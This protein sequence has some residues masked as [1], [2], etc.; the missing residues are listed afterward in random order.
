MP[1]GRGSA[2]DG[3][4][5][6]RWLVIAAAGAIAVLGGLVLA[7]G[8]VAM[9]LGPIGVTQVQCVAAID[10]SGPDWSPGPAP[11]TWIAVGLP[12]AVAAAAI[13]PWRRL[14]RRSL[15]IVFALGLAGAVGGATGYD[16]TRATGMTGPTSS[17]EIISVDLPANEEARRLD[18][19]IGACVFVMGG[20]L[21]AGRAARRRTDEEIRAHEGSA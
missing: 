18:A 12:I 13:V 17:G 9:C 3:Q 11:G 21:A 19:A 10:A 20:G 6:K 5:M 2:D 4:A 14:S 8:S 16:A 15:A 1:A 7:G